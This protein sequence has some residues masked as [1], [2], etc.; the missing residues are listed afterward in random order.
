MAPLIKAKKYRDGLTDFVNS[1][2]VNKTFRQR[3]MYLSV[4]KA[5]FKKDNEIF[6]KH[7]AKAI[8]TDMSDEKVKIV[9]IKLVKLCLT[10]PVGYSRSVDKV[11]ETLQKNGSAD[12]TQFFGKDKNPKKYI[13]PCK[14]KL[15]LKTE[16]EEES[17]EP[18]AQAQEEEKDEELQQIRQ[19]EKNVNIRFGNYSMLMRAQQLGISSKLLSLLSGLGNS[20]SISANPPKNP[21]LDATE[22]KM[23]S[24]KPT[25]AGAESWD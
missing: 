6:K 21:Q 17:K 20:S 2:R 9:Q 8:G 13:D 15:K 3:L 22:E 7:F 1:L 12:V 18:S 14:L 23:L 10:I 25:K 11:R 5:T 19:H 16:E 4:A 24:D